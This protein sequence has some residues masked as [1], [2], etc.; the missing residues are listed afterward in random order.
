M[1]KAKTFADLVGVK[2]EERDA[3]F[4]VTPHKHPILMMLD[5]GSDRVGNET[6]GWF[7]QEDF[8]PA[9]GLKADYTLVTEDSYTD[10][11]PVRV[12]NDVE[13]FEVFVAVTD[14][15]E[16]AETYGRAKGK[17]L[18]KLVAQS[19]ISIK[20]GIERRLAGQLT[21]VKTI[22]ASA[23]TAPRAPTST[24]GGRMGNLLNYLTTNVYGGTS[25]TPVALTRTLVDDMMEGVWTNSKDN[26]SLDLVL[27]MKQ[28]RILTTS[29]DGVT[30]IQR[31]IKGFGGTKISSTWSS[32]EGDAGTVV[33]KP[34]RFIGT[35]I[36]YGLTSEYLALREYKKAR[37]KAL[38]P[39]DARE[40]ALCD[41]SGSVEVKNE[42]AL[43]LLHFLT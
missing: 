17:K 34:S 11:E 30:G 36:A 19:L 16:S 31:N 40:R 9:A 4:N 13:R 22:A 15:A 35:D 43:G 32:Y 26:G 18:K 37:S 8:T 39:I 14:M 12:T 27:S 10:S 25:G 41:W 3:I 5:K 21:G 28:K 38:A 33:I 23:A 29:I 6:F 20:D 42:K 2:E 7:T 24:V 1:S